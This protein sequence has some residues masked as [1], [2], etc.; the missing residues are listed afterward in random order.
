MGC[1]IGRLDTGV[2]GGG[3]DGAFTPLGLRSCTAVIGQKET[4]ESILRSRVTT[5]RVGFRGMIKLFRFREIDDARVRIFR[6]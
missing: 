4:L 1:A 3:D 6:S 5:N 2:C